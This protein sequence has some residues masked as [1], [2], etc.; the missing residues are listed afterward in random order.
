MIAVSYCANNNGEIFALS[1]VFSENNSA[2]L[3]PTETSAEKASQ[4]FSGLQKGVEKVSS[5]ASALKTA[6]GA[7]LFGTL[8]K[9]VTD[10]AIGYEKLSISLGAY[11]VAGTNS[12]ALFGEISALA[13]KVHAA[14]TGKSTAA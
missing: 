5:A 6:L 14:Q 10:L 11:S 8:A 9:E 3:A 12:K 1:F 7:V 2:H 4:S 13:K